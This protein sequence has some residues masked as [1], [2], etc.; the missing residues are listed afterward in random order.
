MTIHLSVGSVATRRRFH[1]RDL[2]AV[3][4]SFCQQRYRALVRPAVKVL[5]RVHLGLLRIGAGGLGHGLLGGRVVI[6]TTVGRTSGRA[7]T[8]PLVYM[9]HGDCLVVAASCGGS[10]RLPD[11]WLN[12]QHQPRALIEV[13]GVKSTVEAHIAENHLL[14]QLTQEFE[15]RFP[16]MHFYKRM[17]A[18]E[19]PLVV[20]KPS[21]GA[22]VHGAAIAMAS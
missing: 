19:I 20:L 21:T 1:G 16:Q 3:H 10:E 5:A 7:R 11:W 18:R 22:E 9:R 12:L 4:V 8:T 14:S 13:S 6:L 17:S 15:E 2:Q